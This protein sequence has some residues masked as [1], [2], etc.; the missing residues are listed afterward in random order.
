MSWGGRTVQPA[1]RTASPVLVEVGLL[2]GFSVRTVAGEA[3][4]PASAQRVL[5]HLGLVGRRPRRSLAGQLWPEA[6]EQHAQG[7]LRSALWR[8]EKTCPGLLS[9]RSGTLALSDGVRVDVHALRGWAHAALDPHTAADG[10]PPSDVALHAEL[11]PGWYEDWVLLEREQLHQ[12]RLHA[13]EALAGK[14]GVAGR[15]GEALELAFAAVLGEPLRESAHRVV[16]RLH[17]AEGNVGEARR[18][19][20]SYRDLLHRELGVRP[21]GQLTDL[22]RPLLPV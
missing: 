14:L 16:I 12:L 6:S 13:L 22:V 11:L 17:L 9:T 7:S 15:T 4:L 20:E 21:T 1:Q 10:V 3:D 5:A 2:N 19:Y 18:Q 8:L